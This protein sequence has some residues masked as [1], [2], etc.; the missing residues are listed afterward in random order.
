M[1]SVSN[2]AVCNTPTEQSTD[3]TQ[4]G[5]NTSNYLAG[6]CL[7]F[8]C[9]AATAGIVIDSVDDSGNPTKVSIDGERA[10]I[11][12]GN[13]DFYLLLDLK[14]GTVY[15]VS[16]G[17]RIVINL[18]ASTTRQAIH[19]ALGMEEADLPQVTVEKVGEGPEIAGQKTM[20]YRV[21]MQA[22]HCFDEYLASA[23]LTLSPVRRFL[24]VMA[25]ASNQT[26]SVMAA[27]LAAGEPNL[28]EAAGD[29]VDDQYQELGIPMRTVLADGSVTHE[30]TKVDLDAAVPAASLELPSDY[31]V[32]T[33]QELRNREAEDN[34]DS[35]ETTMDEVTQRQQA[36]ESDIQE[37]VDD[38]AKSPAK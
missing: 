28:C 9:G 33:R 17:D 10:R 21:S 8:T 23:P 38:G 7:A 30:I 35:G 14:G 15:A 16:P 2:S 34:G 3:R 27:L 37:I 36:I 29:D 12:G 24:E 13:R 1:P 19:R 6:L 20:R 4:D 22:A 26:E 31:K 11:D 5:M 18:S 25:A 32:V